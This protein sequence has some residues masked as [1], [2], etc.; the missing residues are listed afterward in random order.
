M[1]DPSDQRIIDIAI[2]LMFLGLFIYSAVLMIAPMAGVLIWAVIMTVALHPVWA[3]LSRVLGGRERLAA[4]LLTTL[5]L[6]LTLGPIGLSAASILDWALALGGRVNAGDPIVPP[7]PTWVEGLP[8]IGDK[9][10]DIWGL[11]QTNIHVAFDKYGD[12][13]L[14]VAQGVMGRIANLG[15]GLL[16]MSVAVLISGF[17]F[18]PGIR[19]VSGA[20]AFSNRIFAP[21]GGDFVT[22]A[23]ATIRNVSRGVIGV[24]AIQA[25]AAGV[26]MWAFGVPSAGP[27]ALICLI[28][29]ILQ[30]GPALVL[31]PVIIWGW[32]TMSFPSAILLTALLVPVMVID[33]FLRPIWMAKGLDTPILV[34]LVGV[35]GGMFAYGLVGIFIGPVLLAVFYELVTEWMRTQSDT[36]SIENK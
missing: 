13:I 11:F 2:R 17:L 8:I 34:I 25:F 12:Q 16:F 3:G 9:F 32:M 33:N 36:D 14:V 10:A 30:I 23:G 24:A 31:L 18:V 20:Q 35:M 28:L 7:V 5:G 29:S 4:G 26:V 22:L 1:T 19:L 6:A 15:F 21:R 27:L